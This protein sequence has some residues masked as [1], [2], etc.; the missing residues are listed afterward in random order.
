MFLLYENKLKKLSEKVS[1]QNLMVSISL[2]LFKVF[3][4]YRFVFSVVRFY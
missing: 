4:S 2:F 3:Y 1:N